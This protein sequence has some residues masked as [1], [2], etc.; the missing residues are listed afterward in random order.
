MDFLNKI[1]NDSILL[2]PSNIKNK[3]LDY[4]ND[5][6]LL[7]N[8]KLMTFR[9]LQ[10]GL[11]YTFSNE[12]IYYVM[13]EY[14][15]SFETA[16]DFI[17]N[18]I[19]VED[20]KYESDKLNTIVK[21]KKGLDEKGLLER[22]P[23]FINLL[24]SKSKMYIYGFTT[25]NKLQDYLLEVASKYIEIESKNKEDNKYKHK[26]YSL[27]TL[28][29]EVA[30]VAEKISELISSGV[31]LDHIYLANYSSEYYFAIKKIFGLYHIPVYLKGETKLS[32]TVIGKY[33][34]DNMIEDMNKHL[35]N[36]KE[37]FDIDN[38]EFN[39]K[40]YNKLTNLVNSYYWASSY[41]E[42]KDLIEAEM[43]TI[44]IPADH[45]DKEILTTNIVD[46]MF[47]DDEYV[48]LLGFNQKSIPK[49][50]RDEDYIDDSIKTYLMESSIEK[51]KASKIR[52][53]TA[54]KNIKN[55]TITLK[56]TSI[57]STYLPSTLIDGDYIKQEKIDSITY[58][59]YSDEFNKL[60]YATRIDNLIKF[61][62]QTEDLK[63]LHKTYDIPYKTYSN[64]YTGID[65]NKVRDKLE[66]KG[67]SYSSISHYFECP[68]KFY[69]NYYYK[70]E[71]FESSFSTFIGNAFHEV[72]EKCLDGSNDIDEVYYQYIEEHKNELPYTEKEQYFVDKVKDELYFIVDAIKDQYET[73]PGE[74]TDEWHEKGIEKTTNELGLNTNIKSVFKG[75]VDKC[76][77]I[78]NDVIIVDYKTGTSAHLDRD[79]F[80]YGIT[81]QLP[82]Y[83]FLLNNL[84]KDY[85]VVGMYLQHILQGLIYRNGNKD[86]TQLKTDSLKLDGLTLDDEDKISEFDS[87]YTFSKL[88]TGLRKKQDGNWMYDSR[89]ITYEDQDKL[90]DMIKNLIEECINKTSDAVFDISPIKDKTVDGCKYCTYRDICFR[91]NNDINYITPQNDENDEEEE[92]GDDYE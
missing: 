9:E 11:L 42:I 27:P 74:I 79:H 2:V 26:A 71:E 10:N 4:I 84:N 37:K 58:S 61:N 47:D 13:K 55:L 5:N 72:L 76:I 40:V 92:E 51:N 52:Y 19:Y 6:K 88:I 8:I 43:K 23:L 33:F 64:K 31:E 85:T 39:L 15:L 91:R 46:N 56:E 77:F 36:I 69:L 25:I 29:D 34:V 49:S 24:K 60:L 7:L 20:K 54:I 86:Y 63:E 80:E 18:T 57:S 81:I 21:I 70:L 78:G 41:L 45:Y 17:N 22:D 53:S 35:N 62:E 12:A 30:Y 1:E 28:E 50:Y 32:D 82:I 14:N 68:F 59:K 3:L 83:L 16:K 65:K 38:N 67:Y 66:T 75:I 73:F 90:Y 48:F 89:I 44:S 87:G